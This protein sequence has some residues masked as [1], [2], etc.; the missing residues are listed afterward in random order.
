[1]WVLNTPLRIRYDALIV[2]FLLTKE[3]IEASFVDF[4]EKKSR[5]LFGD[6]VE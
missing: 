4:V 3:F 2:K 1:M 6:E 5:L